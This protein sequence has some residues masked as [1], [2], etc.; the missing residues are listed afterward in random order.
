MNRIIVMVIRN[1]Y[2][3]P[4]KWIKLCWYA[5]HA[6]KYTDDEHNLLLRD[7]VKHANKGGSVTIKVTGR[8]NVPTKDGFMY[9]PNHQGMYDM[10]A[11][12]EASPRPFSA[13]AKKEIKNIPFLKQ[14]LAC[15]RAFLL[16]RKDARQA[17]TVIK[18][19]TKE[20][21]KGRNY[22]IF[23]EGTRSKEGNMTQEFKGGS[24]KAAM[25]AKCPIV[26]VALIDSFKPFDSGIITPVT[27]E[28]HFLKPLS[29]EDYKDLKTKELAALV[30]ER[31]DEEIS[32]KY[33]NKD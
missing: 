20:V 7:I 17:M 22:L 14:V 9:F 1:W 24:F 33:G 11:M 8:E 6:D 4:F 25:W 12:L 19:V 5:A 10:L 26:P 30:K 15:L 3:V 31:I 27:V 28:V 21:Q 2:Y 29:Y 13:V 32:K 16:D 23:A 18:N